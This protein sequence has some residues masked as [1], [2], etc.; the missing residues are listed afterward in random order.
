MSASPVQIWTHLALKPTYTQ[1][2]E[3]CKEAARNGAQLPT[4]EAGPGGTLCTSHAF[5]ASPRPLAR[6]PRTKRKRR[7]N[8]ADLPVQSCLPGFPLTS[9]LKFQKITYV[10]YST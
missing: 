7:R 9:D 10:F 5:A 4:A 6:T 1:R 3:L 2:P 8:E